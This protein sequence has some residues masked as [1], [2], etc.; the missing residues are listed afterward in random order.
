[1][2]KGLLALFALLLCIG[3]TSC[4]KTS[5]NKQSEEQ[6]SET[7]KFF[8]SAKSS[9]EFQGKYLISKDNQCLVY[10]MGMRG[11]TV[12]QISVKE[13]GLL[14]DGLC[15]LKK[16]AKKPYLD[17]FS[18]EDD[19]SLKGEMSANKMDIKV[20]GEKYTFEDF[21]IITEEEAADLD[22]N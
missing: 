15:T 11:N 12:I 22:F 14:A 5:D 21:R 1:M 6:Q 13:K 7:E 4:S 8:A 9:E 16:D 2:K 3:F 20:H 10:F 17:L 18:R 19:G